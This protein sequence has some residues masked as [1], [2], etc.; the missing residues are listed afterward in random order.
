M[1][2]LK[3]VEDLT[4]AEAREELARLAHEITQANE[5]YHL[6]DAPEI[7]DA[8]YDAMRQR[9]LAIEA[10]FPGL[11][12]ADSPSG[13]VG[14]AVADGFGKVRHEVRMLSLENAFDE[15]DV[16]D[17]IARIR[18]YLGHDG[19]LAF[20]AEPKI[21]GLSLSL[22]YEGGRLVQAATRGDGET[23]ENVTENARTIADIPQFLHGAPEVLEA[24][25]GRLVAPIP[26]RSLGNR[27][28]DE[29]PVL[30]HRFFLV[31]LLEGGRVEVVPKVVPVVLGTEGLPRVGRGA[32]FGAPAALRARVKVQHLLPGEVLDFVDAE[33][34]GNES[35][36]VLI[37][38]QR[39]LPAGILRLDGPQVAANL[40]G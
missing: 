3:A 32:D 35:L 28:T 36:D 6:R 30:G 20:T 33:V 21:D 27:A 26:D 2:R 10:R 37:V 4:E 17:F 40:V 29:K 39:D 5:A 31:H 34:L 24:P 16:A 9:N 25:G 1:P 23:G 19:A 11:K 7:S 18:S 14:A 22:R 12:R 38:V 13:Q 8:D 15:T